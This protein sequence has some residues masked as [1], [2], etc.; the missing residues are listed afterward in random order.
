MSTR[1][2]HSVENTNRRSRA[3]GDRDVATSAAHRE[4][5]SYDIGTRAT[6]VPIRSFDFKVKHRLDDGID[7]DAVL[8]TATDP[9]NILGPV[10]E[11]QIPVVTSQDPLSMLAA[12]NKRCNFMQAGRK[13]EISDVEFKQA[14]AIIDALPNK[15]DP[16]YENEEDRLRWLDKFEPG[17]RKRMEHA[18]S[19]MSDAGIKD[20][21]DK[22]LM[23]KIETL[24]KREDDEWAPRAIYIGSDYHNA[25]D[26]PPMMVAMERLCTLLDTD[27]DGVKLGSVDVKF[28]YKKNDVQLMSHLLSDDSLTNTA[29]GD[30]SRN[31]RE[32]RSRVAYIVDH[33]LEKLNFDSETRKR[34]L[35]SSE[36]YTV[37]AP[38]CGLKARLSHQLPTGATCTTF[39][40]S[41]FNAIM[42]AVACAQQKI[43]RARALILGDDLLART[44]QKINL[45]EWQNCIARFKM[46]L[47]AFAPTINGGATFLSRR[48]I[49]NTTVPCLMPKLGKALARFNV[50]ASKNPA[51]TDHEYMAGKSLAHAYEFR[52][53]PTFSSMFIDRFNFHFPFLE[54]NEEKEIV[55]DSWFLKISGL[56]TPV[57]VLAA[58]K[59]EKVLVSQEEMIDWL[60]ET[61]DEFAD[62]I[63]QFSHSIITGTEYEVIETHLFDA[64]SI[65]F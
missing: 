13:D 59:N 35:E 14:L 25:I 42:F 26:G 64:L 1:Q 20:I 45:V 11:G 49:H 30:Y 53:V 36:E 37:Y 28:G 52:H 24:L 7:T 44:L 55:H 41:C 6:V 15:F 46:V 48:V 33:W 12:F 29:E 54:R 3:G 47:K 10:I 17:K 57:Q 31:D 22:Q 27:N 4:Y 5:T 60:T 19:T 40:N 21:R 8:S 23:V 50:R 34:M 43:T 39:R 62:D 16:W 56:R 38:I 9:I 2:L 51:I 61:Y 32:Q 63:I 65:D 58:V 18:W